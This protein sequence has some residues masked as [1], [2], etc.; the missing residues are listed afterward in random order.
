MN[1]ESV[2]LGNCLLRVRVS[3]LLVNAFDFVSIVCL[4]KDKTS[5]LISFTLKTT[6]LHNNTIVNAN[7][8]SKRFRRTDFAKTNLRIKIFRKCCPGFRKFKT[9]VR[10]VN[11]RV[12]YVA[13]YIWTP[14]RPT[15][16]AY[17]DKVYLKPRF[18]VKDELLIADCKTILELL[19]SHSLHLNLNVNTHTVI[20]PS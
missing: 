1:P 19:E 16:D 5:P 12:L 9:A 15:I 18:L 13:G 4:N 11:S 17:W 6:I 20:I 2:E 14:F 10:N 8:S 3:V 7:N